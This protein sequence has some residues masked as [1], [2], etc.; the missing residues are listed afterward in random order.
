MLRI[1]IQ[2]IFVEHSLARVYDVAPKV[3]KHTRARS[4][5]H[6]HSHS[7]SFIFLFLLLCR[8]SHYAN[9]VL[10]SQ[11]LAEDSAGARRQP[12]GAHEVAANAAQGAGGGHARHVLEVEREAEVERDAPQQLPRKA[13]PKIK[14]NKIEKKRRRDSRRAGLKWCAS[15]ALLEFQYFFLFLF[16]RCGR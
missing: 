9:C 3:S 10:Y 8:E 16:L 15:G 14:K 5:S 13:V 6:S 12:A 2:M 4:H 7:L 11:R 1:A